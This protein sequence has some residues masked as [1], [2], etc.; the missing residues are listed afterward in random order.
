MHA[1][2]AA[3]FLFQI[4]HRI[5]ALGYA[6]AGVELNDDFFL[7]AVEERVPGHFTLQR[8][9]FD[10]V[11]VIADAH[12]VRFHFV[13]ELI[14]DVGGIQPTLMRPGI[15]ARQARHDEEGV[16]QGVVELDGLGQV[17][18]EQGVEGGMRAAAFETDVVEQ[19]AQC[20]GIAPVVAGELDGLVAHLRHG[21]DGAD[22][23][24]GALVA[25]R[26]KLETEGN[27]VPAVG[28]GRE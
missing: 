12:P 5:A 23:I 7:R 3:R 25:H 21:R 15:F 16:A 27:L 1:G 17:I 18:A 10:V 28:F 14:E 19:L 4:H 20:L 26:I 22:E 9:E 6:V 8:F 13:G 11:I 2:D 24:F